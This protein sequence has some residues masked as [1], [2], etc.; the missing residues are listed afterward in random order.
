MEA[1][2]VSSAPLPLLA[3][4]LR[5]WAAQRDYAQRLVADLSDA[6][7]A[8]QPVRGVTM[9]HPAWTFGHLSAY[10]PVLAAILRGQP[11][12]DP[13]R[14]RFGRDSRPVNDAAAYPP[15]AEL[16]RDYLTGHDDLGGA[17]AEVDAEVLARDI[18]LERWRQRF[19]RV[20]DAVVHLMI[21][22]ESTHLG[23]V[24]AWRRAG[25]RPAV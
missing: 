4:V 22:H 14:H 7:M 16:M 1:A 21:D 11:F 6:E 25:G 8:S 10:P 17:L 2:P 18:P 12:E 24:S 9:N 5:S 20:A 15:K 13:I 19:P 3:A 23:Q